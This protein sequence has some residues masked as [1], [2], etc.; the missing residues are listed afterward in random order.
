MGVFLFRCRID[1]RNRSYPGK[2]KALPLLCGLRHVFPIPRQSRLLRRS[3]HLCQ[4]TGA[5][6][7]VSPG[8]SVISIR[9]PP[10]SSRSPAARWTARRPPQEE[11]THPRPAFPNRLAT[12][13]KAD[14]PFISSGI[15][16]H[17]KREPIATEAERLHTKQPGGM[18][19][20]KRAIR[21]RARSIFTSCHRP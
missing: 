17:P 14:Q 11:P 7:A 1:S 5:P 9:Q 21:L 12:I 18:I 4:Q 10:K 13:G 2:G 16:R 15:R 19:F 20:Y 6:P 3:S 8:V